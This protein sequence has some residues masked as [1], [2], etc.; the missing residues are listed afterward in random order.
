M[1][2]L[3]MVVFVL[4]LLMWLGLSSLGVGFS[5]GLGWFLFL[6]A[7]A[8]VFGVITWVSGWF[9]RKLGGIDYENV[10]CLSLVIML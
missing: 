8:I 7:V 3:L 1:I 4:M 10:V 9:K 6:L 5:D 2:T